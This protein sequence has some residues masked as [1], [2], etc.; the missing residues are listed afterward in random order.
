[1]KNCKS[2]TLLFGEVFSGELKGDKLQEFNKHLSKCKSCKSQY[3]EFKNT[4]SIMGK[5]KRL[6]MKDE[7]WLFDITTFIAFDMAVVAS[8]ITH[9]VNGNEM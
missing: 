8:L 3:N 2:V 6:E 1:M 4:L 9:P 5:R 7:F